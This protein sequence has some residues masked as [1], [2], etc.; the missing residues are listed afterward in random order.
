MDNS[1]S[2]KR[3][4][5]L[6]LLI[7]IP[8][9]LAGGAMFLFKTASRLYDG[10]LRRG[11]NR[12]VKLPIVTESQEHAIMKADIEFRAKVQRWAETAPNAEH[13]IISHDGLSLCATAY[14]RESPD[15]AVVVHGYAGRGMQMTEAAKG[16]Y[17]MGYNV[18][19]P[20]CRGHGKSE[21]DYI[22]MGWH[23]RMD[24]INWAQRITE[25]DSGGRIV[26][27]GLSMGAAA[28]MMASGET[29]PGNVKCLIEDCGYT[30]VTEEFSYHLKHSLKIPKF[31]ILNTVDLM[32]RRHA[33]YKLK[34]AS[35]LEQ[36]KKCRLPILFIHGGKDYFVPTEMVYRLYEA[37]DCEKELFIVPD[38]GHGVSGNIS[39]KSYWEKIESF[40]R[41]CFDRI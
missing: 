3:F 1:R 16:F 33:G 31:P 10:T 41:R 12:M 36:I 11:E 4:S 32:C 5:P 19:L 40:T 38:A 14:T 29:L 15:W 2:I 34:E 23:D 27:Y 20:D 25:W 17:D 18:L 13:R 26:L 9:V 35:A 7:G 6:A 28:I 8:V 22:G 21:G 39:R 30:S 37:A 24:I